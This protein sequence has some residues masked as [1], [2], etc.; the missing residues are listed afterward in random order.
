MGSETRETLVALRVRDGGPVCSE[1]LSAFEL[2][3][4]VP[5]GFAK[6]ELGDGPFGNLD[7]LQKKGQVAQAR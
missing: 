1:Y 3:G 5:Y 2:L 6:R 4:R 7:I